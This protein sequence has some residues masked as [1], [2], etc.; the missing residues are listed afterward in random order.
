MVV[1]AVIERGGVDDVAG[2]EIGLRDV[3]CGFPLACVEAEESIGMS[4]GDA[5]R[6]EKAEAEVLPTSA[7]VRD[8]V[9]GADSRKEEAAEW[10]TALAGSGKMT[11]KHRA[12]PTGKAWNGSGFEPRGSVDVAD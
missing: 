10:K 7:A 6:A 5:P 3:S 2:L 4:L 9:A 11:A 12:G 1:D 8:A